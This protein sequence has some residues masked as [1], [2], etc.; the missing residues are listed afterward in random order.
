MLGQLNE[1]QTA[2]HI[3]QFVAI[4][5]TCH[6]GNNVYTDN[7]NLSISNYWFLTHVRSFDKFV[8]KRGRTS[9]L[10]H[11]LCVNHSC[12]PVFWRFAL[13]SLNLWTLSLLYAVQLKWLVIAKR[14]LTDEHENEKSVHSSLWIPRN[15]VCAWKTSWHLIKKYWVRVTFCS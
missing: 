11:L 5:D 13:S 3:T 8:S 6:Y 15:V 7:Q 1:K 9:C 2:L 12:E 10:N 4:C 14:N